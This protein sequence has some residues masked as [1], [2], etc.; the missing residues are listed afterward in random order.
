MVKAD[1]ISLT[2]DEHSEENAT[3]RRQPNQSVPNKERE[4]RHDSLTMNSDD[5]EMAPPVWH[6]NGGLSVAYSPKSASQISILADSQTSDSEQSNG[7][8]IDRSQTFGVDENE[9]RGN[10]T[11]RLDFVLAMLGY[12]VGLGNLWRFPYLCYRNGGGAFLVPYLI[13]MAIVGIPLFFMESCLAQFTSCGPTTCWQFA[14]LVQGIGIAMLVCSGLTSIYY[15]MIIAWCHFFFFASFQSPLPWSGC[16]NDWNTQD[17][18]LKLPSTECWEGKKYMNGTCYRTSSGAFMG[19]WNETMFTEVTG[20]Q[21]ILPSE[22]YW[23]S[24]VLDISDG[25]D[26]I[27][28]PRWQLVLVLLLAWVEC[29]LCLIKGIKTTGKVV[30]FT[31]TFPYVVLLILFFRGVTLENAWEGIRFYIVPDFKKLGDAKVWRDAAVQIF[32]SMGPGWG[33]LI[34]LA[35]YNRFHNN[36]LRDSLFVSLGNCMTSIFGGFVIFSYLGYMAGQLKTD[37]SKVAADGPGLVFV[38]YPAAMNQLPGAPFWSVI[39]FFM[40][41]T[42]GLDSQFAMVETVLTGVCDSFP[43]IRKY[44]TPIILGICIVGFL[45]GLPMTTQGGVYVLQIMDNYVAAWS[46]LMIGLCE[47]LAI[48]HVYGWRRFC[49]DIELMIG[50]QPSIFWKITWLGSC[51]VGI[52]FILLFAWIDYSPVVYGDYAFPKWADGLG[53]LMAIASVIWI[54]IVMVRK[55]FTEK[56]TSNLLRKLKLLL[57]PSKIWGPALVKHRKLIDYVDEFVVDPDKE[58]GHLN[59]G[60]S[61]SSIMSSQKA[62]SELSVPSDVQSRITK[63]SK[64]SRTSNVTVASKITY[65]SN[66]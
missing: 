48:T 15:N 16:D 49:K 12:A 54:P 25:V 14:P 2:M 37:V 56:E 5:E 33:G 43:D 22:E 40:L 31:A 28:S 55:L 20:R 13:F 29:F 30:Y 32:Y 53:W 62:G 60:Y 63:A 45:L 57:L 1:R 35:S 61:W 34:A 46:L 36:V 39:F 7:R 9:A 11:G 65:E 6:T 42:L 10:W 8:G 23:N 58:D 59:R 38:I 50:S 21:R 24:Y 17:C 52:T 44:K 47:V 19:L 18:R 64:A 4:D 26:N 27:G 3:E 41:I 66:I 51:P